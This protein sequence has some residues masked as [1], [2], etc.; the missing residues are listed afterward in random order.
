MWHEHVATPGGEIL[1]APPFFLTVESVHP[2]G[3][4]KG[5]TFPLGDK[6]HPWG[7]SSPLGVKFTPGG[8]GWS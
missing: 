4:T 5:W 1:F 8:Q 7:T 2:F 6:F 3:W